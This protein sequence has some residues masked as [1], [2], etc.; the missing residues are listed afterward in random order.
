[1]GSGQGLGIYNVTGG[2]GND[3]ITAGS[4]PTTITGNGGQDTIAA[5]SASSDSTLSLIHI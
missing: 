4:G 1:M 3:N 2:T 5:L